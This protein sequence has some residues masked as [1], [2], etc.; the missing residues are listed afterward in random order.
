MALSSEPKRPRLDTFIYQ[1][2]PKDVINV[3]VNSSVEK[4]DDNAFYRCE[5]LERVTVRY[6]E[7]SQGP[8]KIGFSAFNGCKS[9]MNVELPREH[10]LVA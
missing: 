7:L 8:E 4:I 9:L 10:S 1:P 6:V 3:Q 5:Q 2:I